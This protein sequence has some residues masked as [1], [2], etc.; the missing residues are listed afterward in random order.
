MQAYLRRLKLKDGFF[1]PIMSGF[2]MEFPCSN[3]H[4]ICYPD[5][6]VRNARYKMFIESGMV[7]QELDGNP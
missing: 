3:C 5:K 2:M 4:L 7:I 1:V 6:E